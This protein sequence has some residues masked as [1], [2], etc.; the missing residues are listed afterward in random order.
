MRF[1]LPVTLRGTTSLKS[2]DLHARIHKNKITTQRPVRG[3]GRLMYLDFT[4]VLNVVDKVKG[5]F[6]GLSQSNHAVIPQH[7]NLRHTH[8][9]TRVAFVSFRD[10]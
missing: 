3:D 7:Q 6:D 10:L 2:L 4:G 8:T 1:V 5:L 9:H